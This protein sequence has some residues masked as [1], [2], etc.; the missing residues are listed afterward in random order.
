[1]YEILIDCQIIIKLR[2]YPIILLI[3]NHLV[4]N[5]PYNFVDNHLYDGCI[6]IDSK[7]IALTTVILHMNDA[8]IC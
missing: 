2:I 8:L 7:I 5:L 3:I 1:M 4:K 6:C